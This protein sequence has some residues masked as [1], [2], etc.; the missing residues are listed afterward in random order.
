MSINLFIFGKVLWTIIIHSIIHY[1]SVK[2]R[3]FLMKKFLF[4]KAPVILIILS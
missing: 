3:Y 2:M 4:I 1:F